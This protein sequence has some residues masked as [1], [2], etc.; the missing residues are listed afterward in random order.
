MKFTRQPLFVTAIFV[1]YCQVSVFAHRQSDTDTLKR[2]VFIRHSNNNELGDKQAALDH[3]FD[4]SVTLHNDEHHVTN[5]LSLLRSS[6]GSVALRRNLQTQTWRTGNYK[7]N[8]NS[9]NNNRNNGINSDGTTGEYYWRD[10]LN[11]G[12]RN[13]MY[14]II[15]WFVV[16]GSIGTVCR[17]YLCW[18]RI[19][20]GN[21]FRY[22]SFND[23]HDNNNHHNGNDD[24]QHHDQYGD[25]E[26]RMDGVECPT[27]SFNGH[28]A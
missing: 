21:S 8:N 16:I 3:T 28:Q 14:A 10:R 2:N 27:T 19:L 9:N 5:K 12:L 13:V 6:D 15:I 24:Y 4:N 26:D 11:K 23:D 25:E 18:E 7:H 22:N 1:L 17:C 20:S